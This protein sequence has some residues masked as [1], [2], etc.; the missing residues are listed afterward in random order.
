MAKLML[1][2]AEIGNPRCSAH[3]AL[4]SVALNEG[5]DWWDYCTAVE[6]EVSAVTFHGDQV[7]ERGRVAIGEDGHVIERPAI[8]VSV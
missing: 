2:A 8:T 3:L 5:I 1:T 6:L 7:D 4:L